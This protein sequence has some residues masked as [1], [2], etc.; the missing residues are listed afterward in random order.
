MTADQTNG[1]SIQPMPHLTI[2][3]LRELLDGYCDSCPHMD[4]SDHH[5]EQNCAVPRIHA[6]LD[7]YADR[8]V[9]EGM[10]PLRWR[11]ET[12]G[13]VPTDLAWRFT[14]EENDD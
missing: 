5:C 13:A 6:D 9:E 1:T 7:K 14:E 11:V 2:K 12:Q 4:D 3:L 10:K 8:C